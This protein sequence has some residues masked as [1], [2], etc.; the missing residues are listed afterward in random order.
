MK[1]LLLLLELVLLR[2]FLLKVAQLVKV[3]LELDEEAFLLDELLEDDFFLV[4]PPASRIAANKSLGCKFDE[5]LDVVEEVSSCGA[6]GGAMF[7]GG[8]GGAGIELSLELVEE[9]ELLVAGVVKL[10]HVQFEHT[11]VIDPSS[12][13]ST[14]IEPPEFTF[15][16]SLGS[17][18]SST[19]NT[20]VVSSSIADSSSLILILARLSHLQLF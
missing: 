5:L 15:T 18:F 8:G 1:K 19:T 17:L 3:L 20:F 16:T 11:T 7:A 2:L 13:F 4:R 6:A 14:T 12:L 10:F 9:A